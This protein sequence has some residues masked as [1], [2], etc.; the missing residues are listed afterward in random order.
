MEERRNYLFSIDNEQVLNDLLFAGIMALDF[1]L[2]CVW[3][4]SNVMLSS[5]ISS[6]TIVKLIIV[7]QLY[8]HFVTWTF[9]LLLVV[10]S[11]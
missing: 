4:L 5:L 10:A 11:Y 9:E 2:Y 7:C 3:C 8:P 1:H 6:I